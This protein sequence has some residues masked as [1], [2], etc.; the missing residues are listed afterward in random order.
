MKQLLFTLVLLFFQVTTVHGSH[1]DINF[2]V[3]A[4]TGTQDAMIT[5]KVE[6]QSGKKMIL[7]FPTSQF[8]EYVVKDQ[9]GKEIYRYS[10]GKS[11]AQAIQKIGVDPGKSVQ[12]EDR[13]TYPVG[14][15]PGVYTI[16]ASL[17]ANMLN[18]N[19]IQ[20]EIKAETS[21]RILLEDEAFRKIGVTGAGGKYKV[22][23]ELNP[24]LTE[25]FYLVEDGHHQWI[26]E[27]KVT[28]G[29]SN[30]KWRKFN[31]EITIPTKFL[32]ENGTLILFL[33]EKKEAI[34]ETVNHLPV[35]LESFPY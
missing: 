15:K 6:N 1:Q 2:S 30:G 7:E 28:L 29:K 32:P 11:F 14:M 3:S 21:A 19:S 35:K 5:L 12:W 27:R 16:E 18:G 9:K 20:K 4:E 26:S 31:L 34:G 33:Y 24:S 17:K 10:N 13:W 23:G 8:Y 25:F 22:Q